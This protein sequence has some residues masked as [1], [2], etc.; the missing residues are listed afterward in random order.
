M[1]AQ[2]LVIADVS[3]PFLPRYDGLLVSAGD[4][5][6]IR[7]FLT[8]LPSMFVGATTTHAAL[9]PALEVRVRD[10]AVGGQEVRI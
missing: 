3:D 10:E 8:A 5:V 6:N 4:D 1:T 9:G 2:A 7:A